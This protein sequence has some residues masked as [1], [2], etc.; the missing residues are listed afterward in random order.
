MTDAEGKGLLVRFALHRPETRAWAMYDWA[1]SAFMTTI[2]AAVFPIYFA[3]VAAAGLDAETAQ[4]RFGMATTLALVV[5]ALLAPVLGAL[6]DFRAIKKKLLIRFALLGISAT[7]GMYWIEQGDWALALTLFVLAN[8]G[9]AGSIVFYDSLLPHV[10]RGNEV[11]RLSTSGFALGYVGGGLLLALNILWIQNPE[12]FGLSG[13]E[14]ASSSAGTRP[15]RLAFLS[16]AIWWFLFT[17]PLLRRIPEP[18]AAPIPGDPGGRGGGLGLALRRNLATWRELRRYK[19]AALM[20]LAFLLFNDGI[21]TVIRMAVVYATGKGFDQAVLI[22]TILLVQFVGIPCAFCF[23]LLAPRFGAKRLV[24]GGL[25]VYCGI[26]ALAF[27]MRTELHFVA[28]GFLVG[29]VQGGT[30][31]L[32]RS[33]FASL[34]PRHRSGEFFAL[35]AI[36]EKFAG[37]FGPLLFSLALLFCPAEFAI[38]SLI[39]FFVLG[40]LILLRVDVDEGRRVAREAER[41]IEASVA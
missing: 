1:N 7:A 37:I 25:A 40:G 19:H 36:G 14:D 28:L 30:Q 21:V 3:G 31:G 39:P 22:Q 5:I 18:A 12:L 41:E 20:L 35:F 24:L 38:L 6:A 11:D 8:I 33:L 17:I 15:T 16:V 9:A 26:T 4:F 23:G 2:I 32:S 34:I 29:T 27:F 13:G 10:A